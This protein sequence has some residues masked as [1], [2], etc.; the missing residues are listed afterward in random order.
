MDKKVFLLYIPC[1]NMAM[2]KYITIPLGMRT[3][4]DDFFSACRE[5]ERLK[6]TGWWRSCSVCVC[7]KMRWEQE[8]SPSTVGKSI[9]MEE[10]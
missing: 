4:A 5:K 10:L 7:H 2:R 9:V 8:D 1:R 6:R 3:V